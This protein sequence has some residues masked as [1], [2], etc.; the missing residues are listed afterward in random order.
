MDFCYISISGGYFISQLAILI[1]L[2][3]A[4]SMI[5]DNHNFDAI[6]SASGGNI[7]AYI[8][9][10]FN[11]N[12]TSIERKL[13]KI[14]SSMFVNNWNRGNLNLSFFNIFHKSLYR[15][16]IGI[17][18]FFINNYDTFNSKKYPEIW[19]LCYN[20]DIDCGTLFCSK[21]KEHCLLNLDFDSDTIKMGIGE[22]I[23]TNSDMKLI[24]DICLGSA[25]IPGIVKPV[26]IN[27]SI[28]IDGGVLNAT[29]GSYFNDT[30]VNCGTLHYYYILPCKIYDIDIKQKF[31]KKKKDIHWTSNLFNGIQGMSCSQIINDK[32]CIFENW[33]NRTNLKKKDLS[34]SCYYDIKDKNLYKLLT[35]LNDKHFFMICYTDLCSI[36]ISHFSS[37]DLIQQFRKGLSSVCVEV[38]YNNN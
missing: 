9:L 23:Y 5:V 18:D 38:Y 3:K 36:D 22:I 12:E 35:E 7:A 16:G 26:K 37:S 20:Q 29:S 33:K 2:Y 31:I 28:Y 27:N 6:F 8:S 1:K 19:S 24:S 17:D 32:N 11:N 30:T 10:L 13:D 25:A 4:R 21:S 14:S 34:Y 15:E